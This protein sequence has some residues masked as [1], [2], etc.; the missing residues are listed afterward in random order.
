MPSLYLTPTFSF[1][2]RFRMFII[3]RC[4]TR[5]KRLESL[6]SL[7]VFTLVFFHKH[8]RITGLL[9]KHERISLTHHYHSTTST[10]FTGTQTGDCFREFTSEHSQQTAY[11]QQLESNW[12]P[13]FSGCKSLTTKLHV[14]KLYISCIFRDILHILYL[15][16]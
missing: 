3:N 7:F 4:Y 2:S 5:S 12:E 9:E 8:S 1:E 6:D 14:L 15:A 16:C 11:S 13:Q 10:C